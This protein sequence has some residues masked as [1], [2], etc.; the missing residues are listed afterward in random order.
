[1]IGDEADLELARRRAYLARRH[2]LRTLTEIRDRLHPRA[3]AGEAWEKVRDRGEEM[4]AG[5]VRSVKEKPGRAA[6]IAGAVA[7]FLAR[8]PIADGVKALLARGDADDGGGEAVERGDQ[9]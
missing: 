8:K 2:L 6:A 1:M 4:A 7:L 5:A 9:G 3:L